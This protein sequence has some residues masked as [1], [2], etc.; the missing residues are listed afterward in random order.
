MSKRQIIFDGT[1]QPAFAVIPWREY[2]RLANEDAEAL[3]SDEELY[4]H[5]KIEDGE[6]FPIEVADHL[7][8][9]QNSV[10]VYR[11][12]RSM[13]QK[14]LAAAAGINSVYLSQI[15]TGK[16]TGSVKTLAALAKALNV[17]VDDLI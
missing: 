16:R 4:D 13:T 14:E 12:H 7:L 9:G 3:L 10:S 8:A 11:R 5:A 1:G 6:S 15:E 17:T 2:E